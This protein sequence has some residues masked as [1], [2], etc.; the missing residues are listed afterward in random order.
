MSI[1]SYVQSLLKNQI[2]GFTSWHHGV[3]GGQTKEERNHFC[4]NMYKRV[5]EARKMRGR[6]G[7]GLYQFA[8]FFCLVLD[9]S[10]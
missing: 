2:K 5:K 6:G 4:Q 7:G 10:T 9:K 3:G 8:W 1:H